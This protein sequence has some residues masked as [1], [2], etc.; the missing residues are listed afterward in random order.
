M[1]KLTVREEL[2]SL[3]QSFNEI[4]KEIDFLRAKLEKLD[5]DDE[6]EED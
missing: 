5:N 1:Q 3:Q 6:E 2:D 4:Q